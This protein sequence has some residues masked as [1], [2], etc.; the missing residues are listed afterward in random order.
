MAKTTKSEKKKWDD[1]TLVQQIGIVVVAAV[2]IG[3][4]VAALW[5]LVHRSPD[6][7]RGERRL[8]AGLVFINW[9]GPIAYFTVG[10]KGFLGRMQGRC[11]GILGGGTQSEEGETVSL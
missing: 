2:Q 9:V 6:E 4:L 11:S 3:L 7:V 10:R 1:L 8:W 5:D